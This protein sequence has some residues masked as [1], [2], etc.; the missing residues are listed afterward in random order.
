MLLLA[1]PVPALGKVFLYR[2][3]APTKLGDHS[4]YEEEEGVFDN[5]Y[6]H[7]KQHHSPISSAE[8]T[9]A[10]FFQQNHKVFLSITFATKG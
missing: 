6:G 8:V 2:H 9:Q 1:L 7:F 4:V 5:L 3:V 10:I